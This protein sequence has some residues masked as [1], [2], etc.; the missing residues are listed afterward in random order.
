MGI[1]DSFDKLCVKIHNALQMKKWGGRL[2][3]GKN[4]K[5]HQ[6]IS[7]YGEG[8]IQLSDRCEL[9]Y[10]IGGGY[11][12]GRC[13]LQV[14]SK[15]AHISIG[16]DVLTNNNLFICAME[17]V[18]IGDKCLIGRNVTIMDHNA[19]GIRPECRRTS[20]GTV[21]PVNI[22]KNVWIGNYVTILPETNIGDNCVVAAGSVV[23]GSFTDGVI[24]Q[25]NPGVVLRKI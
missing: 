14:R 25:G 18:S 1:I 4:V 20:H 10:K 24:I 8:S 5:L 9:G 2:L 7:L 22:G 12:E 13:E 19:H 16:S 15:N 23:K 11:Y 6:K 3:L 17:S 21:R